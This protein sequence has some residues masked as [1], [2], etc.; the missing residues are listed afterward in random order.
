MT[1]TAP[2]TGSTPV[3]LPR[4]RLLDRLGT[5]ESRVVVLSAPSGS[6]NVVQRLGVATSATS[7]NFEGGQPIV[8]A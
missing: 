6:G 7:V 4:P 1:G 5:N 2:L 8:L 3:L